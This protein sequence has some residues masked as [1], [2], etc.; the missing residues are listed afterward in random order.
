[1]VDILY[2]ALSIFA[3]IHTV[4]AHGYVSQ[5]TIDGTVY[6]GNVPG[7]DA[8]ASAIRQISTIDPVKGASNPYL[9]CGQDAQLASQAANANPGSNILVQWV[10][11]ATGGNNWPHNVGPI[12]AYLAKC[13]GE[14]SSYNSSNA[15]WFKISEL[16]LKPG[17]TTWYQADIMAGEP[18]NV[19]LPS[20]LASGQYLLR[21]ELISLQLAV[22]EGGAE[23][24]PSCTQ[25]NVGGSQSG[26][27]SSSD[28]VKFPGGYSDSDPGIY[29]PGVYNT[30]LDNYVFP[31]PVI[32]STLD[33][34]SG[35]NAGGSSGSG[36]SG[37]SS[38]ASVASP[39]STPSSPSASA[40]GTA[41][42]SSIPASASGT[43]SSPSP[44]ATGSTGTG[45]GSSTTNTSSGSGSCKLKKKSVTENTVQRR[46]P[47]ALSRIMRNLL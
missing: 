8:A 43:G 34:A 39:S 42:A 36:S 30:P 7:K 22:S 24:Y 11:G 1:M 19:T 18:A 14:C 37:S 23:F 44:S 38:S 47:K 20:N 10:G 17:N 2:F 46:H 9:N 27:V 28:E 33:I 35:N 31:G 4:A 21:H 6:K 5:V 45:T 29:V 26:T 12:M 25:L 16:G 41:S 15:E 3:F 32:P 13:D 40:S